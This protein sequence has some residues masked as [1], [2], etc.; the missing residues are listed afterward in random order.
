MVKTALHSGQV[1][2]LQLN[3][4]PRRLNCSMN[5][6]LG[7]PEVGAGWQEPNSGNIVSRQQVISPKEDSSVGSLI[8]LTAGVLREVSAGSLCKGHEQNTDKKRGASRK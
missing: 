7:F 1:T 5:T 6:R 4:T 8:V 2:F 3:L